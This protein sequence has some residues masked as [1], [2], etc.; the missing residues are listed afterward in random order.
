L[1]DTLAAELIQFAAFF[2]HPESAE[3]TMYKF[4]LSLN[5]S[6]TFPNVEIALRIYL[7]MTM[8]NASGGGSF[9]KLGTV[10]G[11]LRS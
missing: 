6:Q 1:E 11:D 10:E 2:A 5:L 4:L 8:F 9:S 3:L 7:C